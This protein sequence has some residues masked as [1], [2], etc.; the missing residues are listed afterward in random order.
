MGIFR[1]HKTGLQSH[2]RQSKTHKL[3]PAY[4]LLYTCPFLNEKLLPLELINLIMS[5]LPCIA[6][7]M[8]FRK[9]SNQ[10]LCNNRANIVYY[11]T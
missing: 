6:C 9:L 11:Q 7:S 10:F 1:V 2:L 8:G 5:Q 3:H 4:F